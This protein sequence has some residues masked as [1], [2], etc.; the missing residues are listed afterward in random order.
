MES[1]RDDARSLL[2]RLFR[3]HLEGLRSIESPDP[4][5]LQTRELLEAEWEHLRDDPRL[6]PFEGNLTPGLR[7][8]LEPHESEFA[9]E[10]PH[11]LGESLVAALAFQ[12]IEVRGRGLEIT[13]Y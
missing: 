1:V 8:A 5:A 12:H 10:L 9:A 2:R 3:N 7:D 4:D 6:F 13:S 11:G